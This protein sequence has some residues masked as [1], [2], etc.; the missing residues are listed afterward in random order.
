MNEL[1]GPVLPSL[2]IACSATLL[3][4]V[5]GIPLGFHIAVKSFRGK[6][7]L[8]TVLNTLLALP[9]VVVGLFVFT[10]ICGNSPLGSMEL[11][12]TIPAIII[13]QVILALP[14][15]VAFTHTAVSSVERSARE[16]AVTL[17]ADALTVTKTII[18]ESRFGITAAIAACFGRLIGEV[19]VSMMLG[20]N[21]HGYTRT[22]TTAIALE[23]SKAEF[24][25]AL[26]LGFILLAI[27]LCVNILLRYMQGRGEE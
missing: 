13:G 27:A 6:Q 25:Y 26:H 17:G 24:A 2:R 11:L 9:T 7:L 3:C 16:T 10:L 1:F 21:I 19:G 22:M 23:T 5:I 20:G 12:F 15:M 4:A 18:W 14:I 8:I